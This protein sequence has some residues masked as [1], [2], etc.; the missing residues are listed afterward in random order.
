MNLFC[1][2][3]LIAAFC[4]LP[5]LVVAVSK[6]RAEKSVVSA[7]L[8]LVA[9]TITAT[10]VSACLHADNFMSC[11]KMGEK[12][13]GGS[14]NPRYVAAALLVVSIAVNAGIF[15]LAKKATSGN[16]GKCIA[17]LLTGF[18]AMNLVIG[19]TASVLTGLSL[20]KCFFGCCC[21]AM[22]VGGVAWGL[23]Y[24]EMCVIFNI[25]I[26]ATIC[27]GSALWLAWSAIKRY[28]GRRTAGNA[29]LMTIGCVYGLLFLG[30]F[31]WVCSHYAMPLTDAYYLCYHE[32]TQLAKDWHTTYNNVNYIIFI[33][34]F[35]IVT[36][37]NMVMAK[38]LKSNNE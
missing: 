20:D 30:G 4:S 12:V 9:G 18:L 17:A 5:A 1:L 11:L 32:L 38:L 6:L 37:G 31:L 10:F 16:L 14:L 27:L 2:V 3:S 33:F 35:L 22:G 23:Q 19:I 15:A 34:L 7:L 13:V 25:Y 21:A 28:L 24:Q 36:I 29:L 8:V 26:Q